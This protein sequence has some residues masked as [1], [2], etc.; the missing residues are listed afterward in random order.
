LPAALHDLAS[1]LYSYA[2][3]KGGFD[4]VEAEAA[5]RAALKLDPENGQATRNLEAL[6]RNTGR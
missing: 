5:L 3:L 1:R 6:Y 4:P 2:L